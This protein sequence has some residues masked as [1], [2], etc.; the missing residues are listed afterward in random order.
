MSLYSWNRMPGVR[1]AC[2]QP[3]HPNEIL[4]HLAGCPAVSKP[5]LSFRTAIRLTPTKGVAEGKELTH[6]WPWEKEGKD[7]GHLM[8]CLATRP[9][10]L[11]LHH[12]RRLGDE[13]RRHKASSPSTLS[14]M[15]PSPAAAIFFHNL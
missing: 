8:P 14:L 4:L 1:N 9:G 5:F 10:L 2:G 7:L 3:L 15:V 6:R 13:E 11:Y 12:S